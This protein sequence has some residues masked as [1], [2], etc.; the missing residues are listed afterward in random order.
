[1]YSWPNVFVLYMFPRTWG[2]MHWRS[3][4][5]K[6]RRRVH[7]AK[8]HMLVDGRFKGTGHLDITQNKYLHKN[9]PGHKQWQAVYSTTYCDKRL[10]L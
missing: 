9:L 6:Y 7:S 10:S 5:F 4:V 3:W 2:H 1:M 8:M